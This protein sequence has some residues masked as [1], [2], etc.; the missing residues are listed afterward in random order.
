M[1]CLFIWTRL[2]GNQRS[3]G[4]YYRMNTS[5]LQCC[6]KCD[7]ILNDHIIGV[8]SADMLPQTY[9]RYPFGFIANTDKHSKAGKH[10]CAFYAERP[11]TVE[12]FDSFG[13]NPAYYNAFFPSWINKNAYTLKINDKVVQGQHSDVCGQ[14]CLY[15]L[16]QRLTG[17]S[18][19]NTLKIFCIENQSDNDYFIYLYI[20]HAFPHCLRS[21]HVYNQF[22]KPQIKW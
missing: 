18:M 14:Y 16:H 8:F 3:K 21:D 17:K 19:H 1:F 15:F 7:P 22:C 13:E 20:L 12:F 6:I 10:W 9:Q 5:E 2:S 11:G 4:H